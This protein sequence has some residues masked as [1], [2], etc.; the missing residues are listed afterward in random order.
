MRALCL[1]ITIVTYL[2]TYSHVSAAVHV[3][4]YWIQGIYLVNLLAQ[5]LMLNLFLGTEYYMYGVAFVRDLVL[6]RRPLSTETRF[7]RVTLCDFKLRR[8]GSDHPHTVQCV[9]PINL[10]NEKIFTFMWFWFAL[11]ALAT[12]A[13]LIRW[14]WVIGLRCSRIHYVRRHLK[15][16]DN[17]DNKA[18]PAPVAGCCHL[19]NLIA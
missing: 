16:Y 4:V 13:S 8:M 2:L 12:A 15:V 19:A 11:V 1:R 9:L 5:L 6:G 14:M 10:F 18:H 3:I 7:P 17:N